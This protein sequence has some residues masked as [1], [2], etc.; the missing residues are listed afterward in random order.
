MA[1]GVLALALSCALLA[2][3]T[4]AFAG[5][6]E[7]AQARG[8]LQ[9]GVRADYPP[10]AFIDGDGRNAG[11]E[12]DIARFLALRLMGSEN[13]MRLVPLASWQRIDALQERRVDLV[14]ASLAATDARRVQVLFSEPYYASGVGLLARKD[15]P[16]K[17][18]A[19]LRQ[20]KVCAIEGAGYDEQLAQLG[21]EQVRFPATP[22][23]FKALRDGG[24][25]GLA[26]D[27][28]ALA[29]RLADPEW[30]ADF[31]LPLPAIAVVPWAIGLRRDDQAFKAL[32]DPILQEMEG[33]GFIVAMEAKWRLPASSFARDRMSKGRRPGGR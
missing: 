24:C 26:F 2:G 17:A 19:D 30:G 12:I 28:S 8:R 6:F 18:W 23:A 1:R 21:I 11:F 15:A 3:A 4:D 32:I 31:H 14:L 10:F 7:D 16:F 29:A 25:E 20:R 22:A 27:D 9:V 13:R 5:A 33:S